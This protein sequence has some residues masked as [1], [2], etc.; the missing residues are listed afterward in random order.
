MPK[1]KIGIYNIKSD[2]KQ[3]RGKLYKSVNMDRDREYRLD[4][5]RHKKDRRSDRDSERDRS[6][7][8]SRERDKGY[9]DWRREREGE[10]KRS[11]RH[12]RD[13]RED[14]KRSSRKHRSKQD[15]VIQVVK[16]H[17]LCREG[18]L[19]EGLFRYFAPFSLTQ[20]ILYIAAL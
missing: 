18:D 7:R 8:S 20:Q 11:K 12:G 16:I 19:I 17:K 4:R 6:R 2:L 3:K 15:D 1:T 5:D 9:R 13:S 14:D 10:K